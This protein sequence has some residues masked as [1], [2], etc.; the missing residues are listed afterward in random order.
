MQ[1]LSHALYQRC[2][3]TLQNCSE[4]ESESALRTVFATGELALYQ[5]RLPESDSRDMRIRQT[6]TYLV[7]QR[8]RGDRPVFPLFLAILRDGLPEG[9]ALRD[10]L[11]ELRAA[12]E[13]ELTTGTGPTVLTESAPSRSVAAAG[14]LAPG[15]AAF[16]GITRNSSCSS[17][18]ENAY[19]RRDFFR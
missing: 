4:F 14:E 6:I 3:E 11:E 17:R 15:T 16:R 18:I 9:I 13:R 1:S 2:Y 8:L 5:N 7:R 10:D 12:T 19:V